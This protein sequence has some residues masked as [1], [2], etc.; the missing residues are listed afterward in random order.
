MELLERLLERA[1]QARALDGVATKVSAVV[2]PVVTKEPLRDLL[3]GRV[4]GHPTHPTLV[5]APIGCFLG[6][7]LL[8]V[9][10]GD[11]AA[12]RRLVG[13]GIV[14]TVPTAAAGLHDWVDTMGAE[15]RIG[16]IHAASNVAAMAVYGASWWRRRRGGG[17]V[18]GLLGF[19][20]LGVGGYL[21]GHL[22][23]AQGVGVD[24][25]AFE[26]G[27]RNWTDV[28]A[29]ADVPEGQPVQVRA[30]DVAILLVRRGGRL[31]ALADRCTHRGGPL[32]GGELVGDCIQCPWHGSQFRLSDGMVE[33]GPASRPEPAYDVREDAGRILLRR[34]EPRSLR[35]GPV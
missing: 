33:R 10:G 34:S 13:A 23:Y 15:R 17:K 35:T 26:A 18:L 12:A 8:D 4:V 7:T 14:V 22:T 9:T 21:G 25:T 28:A 2:G 20:F 5:V 16:L 19:S 30:D 27:P 6:A 32:S 31:S 11:A 3:S 29:A 1:E 24:T